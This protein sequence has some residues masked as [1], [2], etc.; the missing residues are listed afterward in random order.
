MLI[1]GDGM[2]DEKEQF[3]YRYCYS[4]YQYELGDLYNR[5]LEDKF[6]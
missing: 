1:R 4:E 6:F 5:F 3:S 2:S